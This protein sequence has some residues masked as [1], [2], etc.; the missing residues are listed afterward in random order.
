MILS[1]SQEGIGSCNF[2]GFVEKAIQ[3]QSSPRHKI[4]I[5]DN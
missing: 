2:I 3:N 5:T 4:T 1:K